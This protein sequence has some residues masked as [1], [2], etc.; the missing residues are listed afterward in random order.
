[1]MQL[2]FMRKNGKR[3]AMAKFRPI[4]AM[5][6]LAGWSTVSGALNVRQ[7]DLMFSCVS[8]P[9]RIMQSSLMPKRNVSVAMV[10]KLVPV[11]HV[12]QN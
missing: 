10:A 1:M 6:L 8:R 3:V 2:S 4:P 9:R 11:P 12:R 5:A 7:Y